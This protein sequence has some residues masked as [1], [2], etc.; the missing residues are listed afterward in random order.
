MSN[1]SKGNYYKI[2]TKKYLEDKGY[3]CEYLEKMQRIYTNG[4][5]IFIKRDLLGADGCAISDSEF[6]LWNAILNKANVAS[7]IKAFKAYPQGGDI[8]RWLF[9]WQERVKEP[10]I[11]EVNNA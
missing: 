8:K 11:L 6:I 1:A 5:V 3:V 10:E 9:I 2:K 4:K 7:H